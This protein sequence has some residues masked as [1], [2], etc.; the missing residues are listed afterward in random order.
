[1]HDRPWKSTRREASAMRAKLLH[2]GPLQRQFA[3]RTKTDEFEDIGAAL[4]V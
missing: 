1:M 2:D 4:A 3:V